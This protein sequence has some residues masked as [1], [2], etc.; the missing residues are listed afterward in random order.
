V[1]NFK[2]LVYFYDPARKEI[3]EWPME[4]KKDL[5]SIL[6]LLQMGE[7]VGMPDVKPMPSIAKGASEIRIKDQ[8][9][10]YRVFFV[11]ETDI[12]VLVFHGFKKK[13]Q[14]TPQNE[15]D[16]GKKRL[17]VFL[18]ELKDEK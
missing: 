8:S 1:K 11:I 4:I 18:E 6:S 10:I 16:T 2:H 17:K 12:G 9:G 13:T 14:Q 5:G 7:S 3:R 15:I